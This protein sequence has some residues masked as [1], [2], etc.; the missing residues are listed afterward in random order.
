MATSI[1]NPT[2][3]FQCAIPGGIRGGM[4]VTIDGTVFNNCKRFA[5]NFK[6]FNN[7]T[8]FHFNPRFDDGNI[9]VCNTELGNKWGS[10]ERMNH[11]PFIRNR[12]FKINITVQED[13]FQVSVNGNH[14]LHYRHRVSYHSINSLQLWGEITLSNISFS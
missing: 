6:C 8:A 12:Y 14:V 13:V 11:M 3:P 4:T 7:D 2:M 9:I 5:V 10:E 1:S